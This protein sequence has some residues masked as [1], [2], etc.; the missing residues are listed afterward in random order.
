MRHWQITLQLQAWIQEGI[1]RPEPPHPVR[2]P[3]LI[4]KKAEMDREILEF[5]KHL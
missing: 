2:E 1:T 4:C 3:P 5:E